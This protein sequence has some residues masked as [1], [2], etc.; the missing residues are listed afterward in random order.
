MNISG[1][2]P[3]FSSFWKYFGRE[4]AAEW[5]KEKHPKMSL[6]IRKRYRDFMRCNGQSSNH[7]DVLENDLDVKKNSEGESYRA[8]VV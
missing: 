4:K 1:Y 3:T 2:I 7:I 5:Q 6:M 8:R